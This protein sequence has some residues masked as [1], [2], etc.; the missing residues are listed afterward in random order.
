[1]LTSFKVS[2]HDHIRPNNP[3]VMHTMGTSA[4]SAAVIP[5]LTLL[6]LG[7]QR[8]QH[9]SKMHSLHPP[10]PQEEPHPPRY[11]HVF[12]HSN[13]TSLCVSHPSV[14]ICELEIFAPASPSP[15]IRQPLRCSGSTSLFWHSASASDDLLTDFQARGRERSVLE[16]SCL[17]V[18]LQ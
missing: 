18:M 11:A 13:S 14:P 2:R 10:W 16:T 7:L 5:L 4:T 9:C 1:M 6:Y 12:L 15:C 8:Q 3:Y 17:C